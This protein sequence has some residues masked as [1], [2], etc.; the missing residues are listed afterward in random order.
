M[1][2]TDAFANRLVPLKFNVSIPK[3]KQDQKL[4]DKLWEE[5][6]AIVTDAL[7]AF[8]D[9]VKR[10]CIWTLPADSIR[11][12]NRFRRVLRSDRLF[13]EECCVLAKD[14]NSASAKLIREHNADLFDAYKI[15]CKEN[16]F[17]VVSNRQFFDTV[18]A[19]D[20]IEKIRFR[21]KLKQ[22]RHGRAGIMLKA[23]LPDIWSKISESLAAQ[24]IQQDHKNL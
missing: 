4:L 20:G 6:D 1:D 10:G 21:N 3:E 19:I 24:G 2:N 22:Y 7:N 18:D 15:W 8:A 16:A 12:I 23:S 13:I 11:T 17:D 9:G 14:C 5:R